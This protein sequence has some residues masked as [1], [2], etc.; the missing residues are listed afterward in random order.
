M[1]QEEPGRAVVVLQPTWMGLE[2]L[3]LYTADACRQTLMIVRLAQQSSF[4]VAVL[5][6]TWLGPAHLPVYTADAC[7]AAARD[8]L[9]KGAH[10]IKIMASGGVASPTDRCAVLCTC[11]SQHDVTAVLVCA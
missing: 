7:R 2:H 8:E 5:Q 6:T 3:P 9:R 4:A 10:C 11:Q 1:A